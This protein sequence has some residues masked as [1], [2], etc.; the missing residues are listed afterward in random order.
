MELMTMTTVSMHMEAYLCIQNKQLV[1]CDRFTAMSLKL[2]AKE[3]KKLLQEL[4]SPLISE[5]E[6]LLC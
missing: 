2:H 1:Y 3:I 4:N 5:K 6:P